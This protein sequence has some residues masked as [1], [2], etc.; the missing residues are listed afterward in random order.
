MGGERAGMS[1]PSLSQPAVLPSAASDLRLQGHPFF[2]APSA[3]GGHG[4][5][6]LLLSAC[7]PSSSHFFNLVH[8]APRPAQAGLRFAMCEGLVLGS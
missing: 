4:L 8:P 1:H 6:L 3:L 5:S 2:P 7:S